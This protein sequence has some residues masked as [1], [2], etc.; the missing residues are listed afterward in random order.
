MI[1]VG[2]SLGATVAVDFTA[3]YPEAVTFLFIHHNQTLSIKP[4]LV[5]YLLFSFLKLAG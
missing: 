2:P 1:L 3:T 5:A 4:I